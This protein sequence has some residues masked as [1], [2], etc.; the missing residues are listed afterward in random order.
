ML[1][2][3]IIFVFLL[4]LDSRIDG[5]SLAVDLTKGMK[6]HEEE[7]KKNM[8]SE[9]HSNI[10]SSLSTKEKEKQGKHHGILSSLHCNNRKRK[11]FHSGIDDFILLRTGVR[12]TSS[13]PPS[14]RIF[15]CF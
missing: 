8:F 11:G 5:S 4:M 12:S 1:T 10:P 13:S 3:Y 14:T 6:S 9:V 15:P 7:V 2:H